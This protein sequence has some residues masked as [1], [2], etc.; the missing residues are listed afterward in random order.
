[1]Q[2]VYEVSKCCL[3]SNGPVVAPSGPRDTPK[4]CEKQVANK[5]RVWS[6]NL[7]QHGNQH[8]NICSVLG[9]MVRCFSASFLVW[10]SYKF[11]DG[12]RIEFSITFMI[13]L[14]F[15]GVFSKLADLCN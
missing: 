14:A 9:D 7:Y 12:F 2:F 15:L 10:I 4:G 1:M 8:L 11:P 3:V 6:S 5:M 13:C